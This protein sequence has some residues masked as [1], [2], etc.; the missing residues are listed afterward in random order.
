[1][2]ELDLYDNIK[3]EMLNC[4]ENQL[5]SLD[6]S[7]CTEMKYLYCYENKLTAL[8]ISNNMELYLLECDDNQIS[9]LELSK[10]QD[11]E[12]LFCIKNKLG[13]LDVS[14]CPKL[15]MLYCGEN[16]LS[17]LDV[18]N[19]RELTILQISNNDI[20]ELD[21][22]NNAKLRN[23]YVSVTKVEELDISNC[24]ELVATF[25]TGSE[26]GYHYARDLDNG[27]RSDLYVTPNTRIIVNIDM[28]VEDRFDDVVAGK[29]YVPFIQYAYDHGYMKGKSD[30]VFG[31]EDGI[32]RAEAV[33]VLYS[34]ENKPEVTF[35]NIFSDVNDASDW[36]ANAICWAN[37]NDIVSGYPNGKFG[38][39]D[40]AS[41]EQMAMILYKYAKLK[42]FDVSADL[43]TLDGYNDR[44]CISGWAKE[45]MAW[46][47]THGIMKGKGENMDPLGIAT[48]AEFATVIKNFCTAYEGE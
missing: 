16:A 35:E 5:T 21:I 7:N 23:L 19:N 2:T 39:S 27:D 18:S 37:K 26:D 43:A 48:R 42:E 22:S 31:T 47:V 12:F 46:A 4:K 24:P 3:M 44:E 38:V 13:D 14:N 1:L 17:R 9:D 40:M 36:F 29:W 8:N 15:K 10:C 20:A 25:Q 6:L 32:T 41:R 34:T 45:A 28:H 11:L 30:T 33:Q